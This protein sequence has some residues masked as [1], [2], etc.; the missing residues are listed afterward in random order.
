MNNINRVTFR[1]MNCKEVSIVEKIKSKERER[2]RERE[3]SA[4]KY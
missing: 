1:K 4:E 2:Q 3:M